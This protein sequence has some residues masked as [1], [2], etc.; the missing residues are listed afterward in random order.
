MSA[1]PVSNESVNDIIRKFQNHPSIIKIKEN[2]QGHFSFSAVDAEDVDGEIDSLDASKAIQQNDIPVKKT[3]ANLFCSEFIMH[4]FN[5][6]ISTARFLDILKNAEVKP[7]FK[8]KSRTDKENYRPVSILPVISKIFETLIFNQLLFEPVFSK[9][10]CRFRKGH[11]A[12]HCLLTMIEKWKKCLDK[13][14]ACRA[15]VPDLSKAFDCLPHSLLIAKLDAY[16]FDKTSTEYL[17]DYLNHRKQEVKINKT[18]SNWTNILHGVPQGSILG[19]LIFNVFLCDLFL[20]KP[21]IDLVSYADDNTPL[22]MGSS[23]LSVAESVTLWFR[24][25]YMKVNPD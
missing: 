8:K 5:E 1:E 3:K 23:Q 17:K 13:N 16:G 24:N 20:F 18:F 11:S 4:N 19:P 15:L 6:G 7:V 21:N 2:H 10:Q 14:G 25:T 12:Q 9:Y 22:A